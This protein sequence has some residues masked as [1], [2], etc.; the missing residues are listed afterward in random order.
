MIDT[1]QPHSV[2]LPIETFKDI[3]VRGFFR[4][5]KSKGLMEKWPNPKVL[6]NYMA[7]LKDGANGG[8]T[9]R[10][11]V[12]VWRPAQQMLSMPLIGTDF[13]SQF[14]SSLI[15]PMMRWF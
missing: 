4:S 9:C 10:C 6:F 1:G 7:R 2:V 8:M 12:P 15:F 5:L 13:L 14:R 3:Q 11:P